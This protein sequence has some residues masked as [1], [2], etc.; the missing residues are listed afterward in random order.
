MSARGFLWRWSVRVLRR[1]WRQHLGI[2][3]LL[4]VGVTLSVGGALTAYNLAEP[5]ESSFGN[6]SYELRSSEPD[7]LASALSTQN[8]RFGTVTQAG[9][10]AG[11]SFGTVD[12]RVQDPANVITEPLLDLIDGTWPAAGEVAVT[13]RALADEP[14][15]GTTVELGGRTLRVVGVVEN[16]TDLSDEFVLT[17]T[18]DG[19]EL[20][21]GTTAVTR[22]LVDGD[23]ANLDLSS[24]AS[25]EHLSSEGPSDRTAITLLV[26]TIGAFGMLEI[27]LLVGSAFAVVAQTRKRQFGLLAAAGA[28]PAMVRSTATATG[29]LI[30]TAGALAGLVIGTT[31]AALLVPAMESTVNHRITFAV[32]PLVA[33]P[34]VLVAIAVGTLA[35]RWPARS[36]S[37]EP[38]VR[39]LSARRP[40]PQPV[41][42]IAVVGV[43]VAAVG[44]VAL[45]VGFAQLSLALA[46]VGTLLTP[47]G[48]LLMSP[49]LV[50]LAADASRRL[51]LPIRLAG[52]TIGRHNRR[53]A[54]MVAA[55]ALALAVPL[56]ITVVTLSIDQ[57]AQE[58]GPNLAEHQAIAWL[59]D[60]SMV[61]PDIPAGHDP[62][63][64]EAAGL[65]LR[66]ALP[67][68]RWAAIQMVLPLAGDDEGFG[69]LPP[70]ASGELLVGPECAFCNVDSWGFRDDEGNDVNY[71]VGPTWLASPQLLD[72]LEMETS[73]LDSGALA[74]TR[75]DQHA[76]IDVR[77][78]LAA[79]GTVP[80]LADWPNHTSIPEALMAPAL[81]QDTDRFETVTVG[82]MGA[83]GD[84]PLSA[85]E[86]A[87]FLEATGSDLAVEFHQPL[88]PRSNLRLIG[89]MAGLLLGLGI[90][91]SAVSLLSAE[92]APDMG[93]LASLGASPATGRRLAGAIA[94]MLAII[95]AALAVLVG[96]IPLLPMVTSEADNFEV[97]IPWTGLAVLLLAFPTIAALTGWLLGRSPARTLSLRDSG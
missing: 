11:A 19:L 90:A 24:T 70:V 9:V 55:L 1:E 97:V 62:A 25:I 58:Q 83:A 23:F 12:A 14:P 46:L 61:P 63:A 69:V 27:A 16:P 39:L 95:G 30:G 96:Y 3:V 50:R 32:P 65:R 31:L 2:L 53:S 22:F 33:L 67:Q 8:Q 68:L 37:R 48:L 93:V 43:I 66:S 76:V 6:G 59:P 74:A 51:P 78:P 57:R 36:L 87:A 29:A 86:R 13:N 18:L 47:I 28:T 45:V 10:L 26:N 71:Q 52:R 80:I 77:G 54:S 35:A 15:L 56:G 4:I 91:V 5:P 41:G 73:W 94:G 88:E 81:V 49:L 44:A 79:E 64:V 84:G 7:Q 40:Q 34:N 20:E 82:W 92:L 75:S 85:A 42:R 60:L 72:V 17:T 38:V 89:L 21:P